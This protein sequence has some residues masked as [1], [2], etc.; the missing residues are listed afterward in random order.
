MRI[1]PI[2]FM[3]ALIAPYDCR[4]FGEKRTRPKSQPA[5]RSGEGERHAHTEDDLG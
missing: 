2:V 1:R 4:L 5:P 3:L